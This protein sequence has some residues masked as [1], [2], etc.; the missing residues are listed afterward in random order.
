VAFFLVQKAFGHAVLWYR[1]MVPEVH[2]RRRNSAQ[3]P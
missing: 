3:R 1:A 2:C